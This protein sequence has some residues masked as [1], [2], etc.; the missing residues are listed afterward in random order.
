MNATKVVP[1]MVIAVALA[2][3]GASLLPPAKIR[4]FD[5]D[6]FGRIPVL[7]GGRV[8][9]IDSVARNSLLVIR[10]QQSFQHLGRTVGPDEWLLD[11][12][13]R[14]DV[15]EKQSVFV[16]DDPEV[17][18][19]LGLQQTSSRY[20]SFKTL[21]PHLDEV[22]RQA[23]A[24]HDIDAKQRTRFQGAIVT[25]FQRIYLYYRL[26]NTLQMP[27]TS[28]LDS[29]LESI[30]TPEAG[31]R[32]EQLAELAA[33][34]PLPP[35]A[36]ASADAW[37]SVGEALGAARSG[38][39]DP[40]LESLARLASAYDENDLEAFNRAV[41]AI[42]EVAASRRP[43]SLN[44]A[45]SERLFNRAQPFYAGMVIY[46]LALL[47]LFASWLWKRSVL[48]PTAFALLVAGALIH[49]AGLVTRIFLQGRPPV[50]N[51]YSS[52]VFVGCRRRLRLCVADR[53]ASPHG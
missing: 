5:L 14:P 41:V 38:M 40:A 44:Q 35:P 51:L 45:D 2:C 19:L 49:T 4:G 20:F 9:P 25:L 37:R 50:T 30:A 26:Q 16:I 22:Q 23:S 43:D 6:G 12:M 46:V 15:A 42:R 3:V 21:A 47:T 36:G 39:M 27:G 34:R 8:K 1:W 17:L 11:V 24:A 48:E 31:Q 32:H 29:E 28:G 33:F 52:A 10:G 13:L 53:R 7:E 18:G